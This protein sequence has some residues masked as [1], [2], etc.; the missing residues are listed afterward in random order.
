MSLFTKLK[1]LFGNSTPSESVVPAGVCPNCWGEQE[2]DGKYR[3]AMKRDNIDLNN[4]EAKLGW[5]QALLLKEV[6][7]VMLKKTDDLYACP[8][9]KLSYHPDGLKK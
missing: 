4:A 6:E 3:E 5:I 8:T 7:G 1:S 2:Y 9:C